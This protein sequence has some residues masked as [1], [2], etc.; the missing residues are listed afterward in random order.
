MLAAVAAGLVVLAGTSCSRKT[1]APKTVYDTRIITTGCP[2]P[3]QK[4]SVGAVVVVNES[5]VDVSAMEHK[6][7]SFPKWVA[8]LVEERLVESGM[9]SSVMMLDRGELPEFSNREAAE[10]FR[11]KYP[12]LDYLFVMT[13]DEVSV[14][15]HE[16][17][18]SVGY[19]ID[20]ALGSGTMRPYEH[21]SLA[22]LSGVLASVTDGVT[23]W[24]GDGESRFKQGKVF[25]RSEDMII[26]SV[27]NALVKM[28]CSM[29]STAFAVGV[30]EL[31]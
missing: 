11:R 9:F 22:R 27:H 31:E 24:K 21:R 4:A 14:L 8:R 17:G 12:G 16:S 13:I 7:T 2:R 19:K 29:G 1:V 26:A 20:T 25:R 10:E 18:A 6:R 5:K 23:R 15:R 28:L 30:K 3:S